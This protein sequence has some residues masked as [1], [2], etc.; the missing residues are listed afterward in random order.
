MTRFSVGLLDRFFGKRAYV[1]L[2]GPDGQPA[3]HSV[4]EKWL[5]RQEAE[6]KIRK[7]EDRR[8][9]STPQVLQLVAKASYIPLLDRYPMMGQITLE[10]W[11]AIFTIA[12]VRAVLFMKAKTEMDYGK[13][14]RD[15]ES[16]HPHALAILQDCN[17]F[18]ENTLLALDRDATGEKV[19]ATLEFALG[20]WVFWNSLGRQ[21]SGEKYGFSNAI[22]SLAL[23]AANQVSD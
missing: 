19:I 15:L 16:I 7:K 20:S 13:F 6:G 22:G 9:A 21:P 14:T 2:P 23:N 18:V 12:S 5:D 10:R 8:P 3:F 1:E 4:T 17:K 11:N